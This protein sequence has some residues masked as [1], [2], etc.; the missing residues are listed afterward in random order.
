[1]F[2]KKLTFLTHFIY[3]PYQQNTILFKL[4]SQFFSHLC[5]WSF[6]LKVRDAFSNKTNL[7]SPKIKGT[8][9]YKVRPKYSAVVAFSWQEDCDRCE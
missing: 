4:C 3:Y 5:H 2:F 8:P 1:M 9:Q 6:D 7:E